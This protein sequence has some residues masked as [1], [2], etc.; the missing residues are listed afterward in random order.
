MYSLALY[1]TLPLDGLQ[2]TE[3]PSFLD[4]QRRYSVLCYGTGHLELL[5]LDRHGVTETG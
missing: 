2:S 3:E 1:R 4:L 5:S